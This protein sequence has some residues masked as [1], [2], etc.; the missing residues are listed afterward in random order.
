MQLQLKLRSSFKSYCKQPCIILVLLLKGF[1]G[2]C[3]CGLYN[4]IGSEKL[5]SKMSDVMVHIYQKILTQKFE[6]ISNLLYRFWNNFI[7][8]SMY[9]RLCFVVIVI[10]RYERFVLLFYIY[11]NK[12][13]I[14][15]RLHFISDLPSCFNDC[16]DKAIENKF[17]CLT[18]LIED[19]VVSYIFERRLSRD[20]LSYICPIDFRED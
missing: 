14:S 1:L 8:I 5:F 20:H 17:L 10:S 7:V 19:R 18:L 15:T 2:V 11:S 9:E 4:A 13:N 12:I 3:G 6:S 16:T